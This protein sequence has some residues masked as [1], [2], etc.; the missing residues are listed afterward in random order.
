MKR[1]G[2]QK[3]KLI[4]EARRRGEERFQTF[5]T[6]TRRHGERPGDLHPTKPKSGWAGAP[7]DRVIARDRV[8]CQT[9]NVCHPERAGE[10]ATA[11]RRT[12]MLFGSAH[13]VSGSSHETTIRMRFWLRD[14]WRLLRAAVR[15]IFDESAYDRYLLRAKAPRSV[16]SYRNFMHER[17]AAMM[18]KP[19]CC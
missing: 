17:D 7:G 4:T 15:E 13:A 3:G 19:R 6:E 10:H 1:P 12:P 2:D 5:T 18:K 16:A 9:A 14:G 11:S 8:I